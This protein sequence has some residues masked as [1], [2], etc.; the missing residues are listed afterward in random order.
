MCIRDSTHTH[1]HT[2]THTF[3]K[4]TFLHVL[5]VVGLQSESVLIWNTIF[6]PSPYF[7]F[8]MEHG[9]KIIPITHVFDNSGEMSLKYL[10]STFVDI[11]RLYVLLKNN[12][13]L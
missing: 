11:L 2:H 10:P 12:N 13:V 3:R 1:T 6:S 4:I 8:V 9:S 5:R 7:Y